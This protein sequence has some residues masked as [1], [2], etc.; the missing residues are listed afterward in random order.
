MKTINTSAVPTK[1]E[2]MA[3]YPNGRPEEK[4]LLIIATEMGERWLVYAP[5]VI[6]RAL[7]VEHDCSSREV[8]DGRGKKVAE[9][10]SAR[11]IILNNELYV[12]ADEKTYFNVVS[13]D[14]PYKPT[15][16]KEEI[17]KLFGCEIN[18]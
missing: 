13:L 6:Q 3:V 7:E 15:I 5:R 18:G 2:Y 10:C 4:V 11:E 14:R 8:W 12:L 9:Y 1:I 17:E 16:K